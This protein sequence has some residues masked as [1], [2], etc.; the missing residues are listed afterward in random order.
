VKTKMIDK[1]T[2]LSICTAFGIDI[3]TEVEDNKK[4]TE[5]LK[6]P[7][8]FVKWQKRCVCDFKNNKNTHSLTCKARWQKILEGKK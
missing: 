1:H 6:N 2:L 5:Y 4:V 8:N 3:A 7:D